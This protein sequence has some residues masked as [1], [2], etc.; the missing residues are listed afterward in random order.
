[1]VLQLP[2][3]EEVGGATWPHEWYRYDSYV[4]VH[5]QYMDRLIN[6]GVVESDGVSFEEVR[7]GR[8]LSLVFVRGAVRCCYGL[9]I[10]VNK[11]LEVK[12]DK[13]ANLVRGYDYSY[14]AWFGATGQEVIRYDMS[15][16]WVGGIHCH[17]FDPVTGRGITRPV[18][19]EELPT[20]D[21]FIRRA[22]RMAEA[23]LPI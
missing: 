5:T 10:L 23:F 16:E 9:N 1:M 17:V 7:D 6:E 3:D 11:A 22:V 15:H 20:L 13:G 14:H 18:T 19:R 8:T 21:L 2:S 4:A 12:R